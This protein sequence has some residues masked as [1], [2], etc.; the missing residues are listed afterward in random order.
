MKYMFEQG[1]LG[2]RAPLFMDFTTL[3]VV[4]LPFLVA[5][6]IYF[7]KKRQY[8]IHAFLQTIILVISLIIIGYFEYGVRLGGGFNEYIKHS[9]VDSSFASSIL[10]LHIVIATI[11]LYLWIET[12]IKAKKM[13]N[14]SSY[15]HKDAG[16]RTF[17]G[18][19]L[20]SLSGIWV[21]IILFI[22]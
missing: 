18:I 5:F 19:V 13:Q 9:S 1:F 7:S 20:T 22:L 21:Y 11:T 15:S 12:L 14:L 6:A 10:I 8:K 3:I 16:I 4:L 17:I 2:T